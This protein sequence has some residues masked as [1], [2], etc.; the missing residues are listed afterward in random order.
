MIG[1]STL[2]SSGTLARVDDVVRRLSAEP[3]RVDIA[4]L[5]GGAG[6]WFLARWQR[7]L[8]RP[9]LVLTVGAG[10]VR[11]WADDLAHFAAGAGG[12]RRAEVA[13]IGPPEID[14]YA[15]L[16]P[17]RATAIERL[18]ALHRLSGETPPRFAVVAAEAFVRR[19]LPPEALRSRSA[20]V[21]AG[22]ERLQ[23]G[24][25]RL[26]VEGGYHRV[27]AVDLPGTFAVRGGLLDVF[28]PTAEEPA[29]I[30]G[31]ATGDGGRAFDPATQRTAGEA[32]PA[33]DP[34][35][36]GDPAG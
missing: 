18:S 23:D 9:V 3:G 36:D 17:D 28:A 7:R 32:L 34:P 24:L 25:I 22:E 15:E 27:R 14:P 13:S 30:S 1:E 31:T 11:R 33:W 16:V 20:V 8:E 6:A 21:V 19:V 29:R 2:P 5:E 35:G 12:E 26:L 4:G 10:R